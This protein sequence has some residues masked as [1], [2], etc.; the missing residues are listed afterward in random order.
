MR[1][2][3][4]MGLY[5]DD[6]GIVSES[7]EIFVKMKAV[8]VTILEEAGLTVSENKTGTMLLRTPDRPDNPLPAARHRSSK[9][10][11]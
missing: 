4:C 6:A 1:A 2:K 7:D 10:E 8:I 5:A 9:P 3:G 11:V